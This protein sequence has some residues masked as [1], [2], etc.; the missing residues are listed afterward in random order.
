MNNIKFRAYNH[1]LDEIYAVDSIEWTEDNKFN[2]E[3]DGCAECFTSDECDIEQFTGLIDKN[4]KEIYEG[5]IIQTNK[6][7]Y[8]RFDKDGIYEVYFN[9]FLCHYALIASRYEWNHKH[10]QYDN[11]ELTG[12][13]TRLFIV[14]GKQIGR[15]H[16]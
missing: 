15:A 6:S 14:T 7:K 4:G 5:D 3:V 10:E 1:E 13:K 2:I 9:K 11:Y 16:V 12:A 8:K